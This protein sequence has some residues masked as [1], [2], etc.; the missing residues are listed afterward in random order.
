MLQHKGYRGTFEQDEGVLHGRVIR[1]RDVIT[2][3]GQ[4]EDEMD[5]AFRDSIDD[6]LGFCAKR[7]ELPPTVNA[8]ASKGI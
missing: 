2:F 3:V 5:Q 8:D 7:G 4:P 1:L 6:Y